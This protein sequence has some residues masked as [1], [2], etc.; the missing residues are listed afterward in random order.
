MLVKTNKLILRNENISFRNGGLTMLPGKGKERIVGE[1][2]DV[3][4][5]LLEDDARARGDDSR[6]RYYYPSTAHGETHF[7][8]GLFNQ[9]QTVYRASP[10][11]LYG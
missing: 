1:G 4:Q 9:W 11:F 8:R 10:L 5:R 2:E 3:I 7:P 6:I